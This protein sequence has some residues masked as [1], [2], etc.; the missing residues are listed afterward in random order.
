MQLS[1]RRAQLALFGGSRE[2]GSRVYGRR[3]CS[4]GGGGGGWWMRVGSRLFCGMAQPV[5][6]DRLFRQPSTSQHCSGVRQS[7]N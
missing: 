2:R 4:A 3:M 5:I 6:G 1:V 7:G